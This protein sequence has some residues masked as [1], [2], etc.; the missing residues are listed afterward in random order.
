MTFFSHPSQAPFACTHIHTNSGT[1]T[2]YNNKMDNQ[3][4]R[5]PKTY[6]H[7]E[8]EFSKAVD[9]HKYMST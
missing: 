6:P 9:C 2:S 5:T 3:I 8:N 1:S 4:N 7:N